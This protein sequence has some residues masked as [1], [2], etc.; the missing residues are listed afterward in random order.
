MRNQEVAAKPPLIVNGCDEVGVLNSLQDLSPEPLG[1]VHASSISDSVSLWA[2][3]SSCEGRAEGT[4]FYDSVHGC[5]HM[6]IRLSWRI[7][8]IGSPSQK[9]NNMCTETSPT[10]LGDNQT[11]KSL[12]V[13]I[14]FGY[15]FCAEWK[16]GTD[17]GEAC[18]FPILC[19]KGRN[20]ASIS[21]A[22][23]NWTDK[24]WRVHLPDTQIASSR[25]K[26][27]FLGWG[28]GL[29]STL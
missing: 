19:R 29:G 10:N 18:T 4:S 7:S 5:M 6:M 16:G 8:P 23:T 25:L 27:H 20:N 1:Q 21:R 26:R 11:S 3:T 28:M 15:A 12:L 2:V 9:S 17:V 22:T 24:G 14:V 13:S